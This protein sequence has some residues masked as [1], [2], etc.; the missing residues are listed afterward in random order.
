MEVTM[1]R[2]IRLLLLAG[3]LL[4]LGAASVS[5]ASAR[6]RS[7]FSSTMTGLPTSGLVVAGVTGA[8]LP[9]TIAQGSATLTSDGRL[10]VEVQGLVLTSNGTNPVASGKA[11]VSCGGT[12]VAITDAVPFSDQ[13]NATVN[14][15]VSL[16]SL[17]LAPAVFFTNGTGKWFAV[18]GF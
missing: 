8:G 2:S 5:T 17:C 18:T 15:V 14:A 13:G 9:W 11:V 3:L 16:P 10:H 1:T 4:V 12:Q 6:G 7:T